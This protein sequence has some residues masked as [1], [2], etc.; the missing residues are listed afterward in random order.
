MLRN[1]RDGVQLAGQTL[2]KGSAMP[3]PI[4][5]NR[6]LSDNQKSKLRRGVLFPVLA[7][8]ATISVLV[9]GTYYTAT[10]VDGQQQT[11]AAPTSDQNAP[12]P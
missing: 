3:A 9:A 5:I 8:L 11:T 10:K 7:F 1:N 12:R 4:H 6:K 2:L